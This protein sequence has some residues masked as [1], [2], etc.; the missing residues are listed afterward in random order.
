M[1]TEHTSEI[2]DSSA[3][4]L[5]GVYGK[6]FIRRRT[7]KSTRQRRPFS[8]FRA[9]RTRKSRQTR[10]AG[11][12]KNLMRKNKLAFITY[13]EKFKSWDTDFDGIEV[14]SLHTNAKKMN[15][16]FFAF[17][18]SLVFLSLSRTTL[19]N[20]FERPD[21]NLQKFD[22]IAAQKKIDAFCRKRRAFKYRFSPFRR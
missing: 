10:N 12:S 7:M 15:P 5:N 21:E 9:A 16:V 17:R 6:H 18:F 20:Y 13:P 4:T 1:M 8:A 3:L 19:A 14:F 11:I 2:Y 22:E